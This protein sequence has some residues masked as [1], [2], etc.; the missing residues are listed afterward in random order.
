MHDGSLKT[1]E[2]V[3]KFFAKDLNDADVKKLADYVRSIGDEGEDYGLEQAIGTYNGALHY[4]KYANGA[5]LEKLVVRKQADDAAKSVVVALTVYDKNGK[6]VAYADV[7]ITD[8]AVNS[9]MV[10]TLKKAI[11]LP[12]GGSYTVAFYDTETGKPVASTYTAK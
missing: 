3:V 2:E 10:I 6:Q 1:I 7:G 4:N 8:V 5:T 12:E 11:T 9:S